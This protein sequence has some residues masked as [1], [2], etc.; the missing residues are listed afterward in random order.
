MLP[1]NLYKRLVY[2]AVLKVIS[3]FLPGAEKPEAKYL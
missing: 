3:K 2:N 1:W